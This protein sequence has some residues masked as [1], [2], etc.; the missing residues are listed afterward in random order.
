MHA[1]TIISIKFPN[2]V[3]IHLTTNSTYNQSPPTK[4]TKKQKIETEISTNF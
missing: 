1:N 3:D 2:Q 4:E